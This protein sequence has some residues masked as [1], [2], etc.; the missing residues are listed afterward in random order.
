MTVLLHPRCFW[1]EITSTDRYKKKKYDNCVDSTQIDCLWWNFCYDMPESP[2]RINILAEF[3]WEKEEKSKQTQN[4][5]SLQ[6]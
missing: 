6:E 2:K 4:E 3:Q 5:T 1:T